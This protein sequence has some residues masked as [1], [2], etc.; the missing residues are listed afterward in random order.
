MRDKSP[1]IYSEIYP[2]LPPNVRMINIYEEDRGYY[3]KNL[4]L[5]RDNVSQSVGSSE[6]AVKGVAVGGPVLDFVKQMEAKGYKVGYPSIEKSMQ[7]DLAI[8]MYGGEIFDRSTSLSIWYTKTSRLVYKVD[9]K[10]GGLNT[11][12]MI[13]ATYY[14][15]KQQLSIKYGMPFASDEFKNFA[16]TASYSDIL[17]TFVYGSSYSKC[18][19]LVPPKGNIILHIDIENNYSIYSLRLVISYINQDNE[20]TNRTEMFNQYQ[21]EI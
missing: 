4:K 17:N 19:F 13:N 12:D 18:G 21:N 20:R 2:A 15:A 1:R 7:D 14:F 10:F 9:V 11:W 8:E 5:N 6:L 16:I 3:I